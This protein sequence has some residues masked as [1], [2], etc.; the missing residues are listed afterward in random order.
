[1]LTDKQKKEYM[2]IMHEYSEVRSRI[3]G[4]FY[5]DNSKEVK[6]DQLDNPENT[7]QSNSSAATSDP[8]SNESQSTGQAPD[9]DEALAQLRAKLNI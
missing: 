1:M 8:A 2:A 3:E 9:E 4:H 7:N 6:N 5:P